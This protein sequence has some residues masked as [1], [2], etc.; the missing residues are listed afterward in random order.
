MVDFDKAYHTK[1]MVKLLRGQGHLSLALNLANTIAESNPQAL[2]VIQ[3]RDEI[4]AEQ[5]K[6]FERF[7]NSAASKPRENQVVE[8]IADISDLMVT[9]QQD[10][11][12]GV[13]AG[14]QDNEVVELDTV[15]LVA[16]QTELSGTEKKIVYL[17]NMLSNLTSRG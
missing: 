7:K 9:E 1:T 13:L 4:K 5:R 14:D 3:I 8:E 15:E 6:N 16:A 2:E 12:D 10:V 11:D 17:Q